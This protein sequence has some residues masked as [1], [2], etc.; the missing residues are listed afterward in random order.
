MTDPHNTKTGT[1]ENS[2]DNTY[3]RSKGDVDS[4]SEE[5]D[6]VFVPF[7][8]KGDGRKREAK[9]HKLKTMVAKDEIAIDNMIKDYQNSNAKVIES[10]Q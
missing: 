1:F 10:E 9:R 8:F 4:F 6:A 2:A 5:E 7:E 3:T